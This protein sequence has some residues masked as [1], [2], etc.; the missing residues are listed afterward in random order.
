MAGS[1][2][3]PFGPTEFMEKL[4]PIADEELK[5]MRQD[6]KFELPV[7][8]GKNAKLEKHLYQLFET[9][10]RDYE[11]SPNFKFFIAAD[12]KPKAGDVKYRP[13][14]GIRETLN[15]SN[16]SD[17]S[18]PQSS[19]SYNLRMRGKQQNLVIEDPDPA[20]NKENE[21]RRAF[22][23]RLDSL[24]VEFKKASHMDP[25]WS[26]E[27]IE[28]TANAREGATKNNPVAFEKTYPEAL[29]V[30]GQLANYASLVFS[31][32]HRSHIFQ[33]LVCGRHVRYIFWDHSGAIVSDLFDY[34]ANPLLLA[35]FFWRYNYMSKADQ[36]W[37]LSVENTTKHE[38][39]KFKQ[40]VTKFLR[41][42][43]D[44]THAQ[45]RLPQAEDTLDDK[46]PVMKVTVED[47][48]LKKPVQ[49]LIQAPFFR[50][51]SA[52]GRAT[53]GYI[54]YHLELRILVFFKD[55]WRVDHKRLIAERSIF[56]QLS[57]AGVLFIPEVLC[58]GDVTA[59]GERGTTR[60]LEWV[61]LLLLDVG[62]AYPRLF[63]HH[64]LLQ[65][66][67]YPV[68]SAPNSKE[69]T[70]A[71]RDCFKAMKSAKKRCGLVH[72]DISLGNVMI[73]VV[74][75]KVTGILAD[76]DHAGKVDPSEGPAPQNFRTGTWQF[77]S[78]G[79]LQDPDKPHETLDD[80][81][82]TFWALV[83]GGIHYYDNENKGLR[84][85]IF[86]E[87]VKHQVRNVTVGGEGKR[88]LLSNISNLI[89][90]TCAP[91]N[92]LIIEI[93]ALL[94]EY[95][96]LW[97]RVHRNL[98]STSEANPSNLEGQ[99]EEELNDSEQDSS[100]EDVSES[101]DES[102]SDYEPNKGG[103]TD[104][105]ATRRRLRRLRKKLNKASTWLKLFNHALSQKGWELNDSLEK[106]KYPKETTRI[107]LQNLQETLHKSFITGS[108]I[109][110]REEGSNPAGTPF[111]VPTEKDLRWRWDEKPADESD[112]DDDDES[113][114][115]EEDANAVKNSMDTMFPPI[116]S[117]S[118]SV[119]PPPSAIPPT[120]PPTS[121]RFPSSY[122]FFS[123]R[124]VGSSRLKRSIDEVATKVGPAGELIEPRAS[125][126]AR[127]RS[128][129]R[130]KVE[131]T[132]RKTRSSSKILTQPPPTAVAAT[133]AAET[134]E[135]RETRPRRTRGPTRMARSGD[136]GPTQPR[137]EG[138][139]PRTAKSTT[140]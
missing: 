43:N 69:Y 27:D 3:G 51:H 130:A 14:G 21:E 129:A 58:G 62:Y 67:A 108:E 80:F 73:K 54:A 83:Y 17:T 55:T 23:W 117:M 120:S 61:K 134:V 49:I 121:R 56:R 70:R 35:Q 68:Q 22:D 94:D 25:F 53:R 39:K 123:G 75:G 13:D 89:C 59:N 2:I 48:V 84:L 100:D 19:H 45:R 90:F 28:E 140:R 64:R 6:V 41:D 105:E 116:A 133:A 16:A 95:Y 4:M 77:M 107:A 15:A 114:I 92:A 136:V 76:W 139:R 127:S 65:P 104:I 5:K 81:E 42:M 38:K 98:A 30:R 63:H 57:D 82:A 74:K 113:C 112:D 12:G 99:G 32:Q 79:L 126:K 33:L 36:G 111:V 7:R 26:K 125:K 102:E 137:R 119:P 128:R 11:L 106:D 138:L 44:P 18:G 40:V 131:P 72:R 135:A 31:Q 66:L 85:E 24:V 52:L 87:R 122:T 110:T 29:R 97:F 88:N 34:V 132:D 115:C 8:K 118:S 96:F 10:I 86:D 124:S 9:T 60:C 20:D 93:A 109:R 103:G 1:W 37:D 47:D 101:S 78:V 91:F 50:T 71:F 46:Y